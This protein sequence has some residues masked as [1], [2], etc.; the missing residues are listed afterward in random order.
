ME[1][2]ID[3]LEVTYVKHVIMMKVAEGEEGARQNN[4]LL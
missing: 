1:L 3:E 2:K 4:Y